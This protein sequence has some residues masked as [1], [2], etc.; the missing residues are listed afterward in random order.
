MTEANL[1][2]KESA[3]SWISEYTRVLKLA[4]KPSRKEYSLTSKVTGIGIILIG[5][6][7]YL[8]KFVSVVI[9]NYGS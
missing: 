1:K 9:Q 3:R 7:G 2:R 4:K 8:L 5:V 6:I